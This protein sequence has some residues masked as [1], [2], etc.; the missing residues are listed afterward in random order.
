M[1]NNE[2]DFL[3]YVYKNG[4]DGY[5]KIA[6]STNI[7][8]GAISKL[9]NKFKEIEALDEKG[10]TPKGIELLKPYKVDN[11]I[12]MAAGMSSR[13]VPLSL[14]MPKGL[15]KV[16]DEILIERQIKQLH[17]AGI[18]DITLVLGVMLLITLSKV[19]SSLSSSIYLI[20]ISFSILNQGSILE[21][22][23]A[24]VNNTSS[25]SFK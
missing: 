7:S 12:I 20:F 18:N 10:L 1:K 15:L 3:Y 5:R 24:L 17:E 8:L 25:P 16:K 6:Q 19:T 22:C 11:A 14:E 9:A 21:A 4:L 23:S 13:F 2:F